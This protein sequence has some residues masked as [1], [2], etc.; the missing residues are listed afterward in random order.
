M[1]VNLTPYT[2]GQLEG[3]RVSSSFAA[4]DPEYRRYLWLLG[5]ELSEGRIDL[6]THRLLALAAYDTYIVRSGRD[7]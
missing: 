5:H 2:K 3:M 6:E 7:G 1:P 4:A